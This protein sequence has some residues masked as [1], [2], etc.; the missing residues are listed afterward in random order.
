MGTFKGST[1]KLGQGEFLQDIE[2][3]VRVQNE[4][5]SKYVHF[6]PKLNFRDA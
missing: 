6:P 5:N 3:K 4:L 2:Q 1:V